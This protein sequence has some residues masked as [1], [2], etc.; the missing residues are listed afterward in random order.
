[1]FQNATRE[2]IIAALREGK[3]NG[4]ISR[5]LKADRGRIR[6]IRN[7]LGIPVHVHIQQPLT[8]EQKWEARTLPV[9]GGHLEWTGERGS[10]SGTPVMR[11]KE[12]SY[13]PAAIAFR[14]ENGRAPKG[15]VFAECGMK[16]CIAPGHVN[17]EPGRI[18][19]RARQRRVERKPFCL[20]G[21]DQAEHGRY[22][23][24]GTAYC[25][26][27]KV[28]WAR[29]E[30]TP[31]PDV[32]PEVVAMLQDG[33]SSTR[34]AQILPVG[35]K[36]VAAIREDLGI[37]KRPAGR[38]ARH[39][40]VEAA[41]QARVTPLDGGHA[42]WTGK[43]GRS[44]VPLVLYRSTQESGYRVAFRLHYG[45]APEGLVRPGCGMPG[46]VAGWHLEDRVVREGTAAAF[47]AIFGVAS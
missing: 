26:A 31:A 47:E 7:E 12:E 2:Q 20:H 25:E 30:R 29:G 42:R 9:D 21:H 1:M 19:A 45:R 5:E 17:D 41:F 27:C 40:S 33:V 32:R 39:D 23:A 38:P 4:T 28:A 18:A 14:I 43:T 8:L 22:E 13:S 36:T 15:Q 6:R 37:P 16:H 11:Y 24:D 10:S 3:S 46:C 35:A 44:G 34:I